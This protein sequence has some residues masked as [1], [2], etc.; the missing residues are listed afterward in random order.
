MLKVN[1]VSTIFLK[2]KRC[3]RIKARLC[4]DGRPQRKLY[5]KSDAASPT[6][7]TESMLLT[8]VE[9]ADEG[10]D[11]AVVDIPGAFLNA[12]L[13]EVVHMRL[14]GVV[15]DALIM[16]APEVYGPMAA[17]NSAGLTVLYVQLTRALYGCLKSSLRWYLQ[18]SR[19]LQ[20]EGFA[21]NPYDSCVMNKDINGS[22][23]TISWHVDD[24]KIS[25]K[26]PAM[27]DE[28]LKTLT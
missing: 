20:D 14:E 15:A 16:L 26:D 11:V 19:V 25:H 18:L 22:Q 10:R 2:K 13:E 3:G 6:V 24:L 27:V 21:E 9:E 28:I 23:C 12:F 7:K 8:A 1:L 5:Q 4:A 17:R